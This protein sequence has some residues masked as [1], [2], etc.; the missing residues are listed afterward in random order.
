MCSSG[1]VPYRA[2]RN[3]TLRGRPSPAPHG[4][5]GPRQCNCAMELF[6]LLKAAGVAVAKPV[7]V[8]AALVAAVEQL[9]AVGPVIGALTVAPQGFM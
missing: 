1:D 5:N 4:P 6:K 2:R 8:S 7:D 3:N 9:G